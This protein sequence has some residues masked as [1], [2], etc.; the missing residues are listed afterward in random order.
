MEDTLALLRIH[1]HAM[2]T[3]IVVQYNEAVHA[4]ITFSRLPLGGQ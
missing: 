2:T 4:R 1:S 3:A